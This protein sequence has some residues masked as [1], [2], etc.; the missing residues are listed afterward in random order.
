VINTYAR[1]AFLK[2]IHL[3]FGLDDTE[4]ATIADQLDETSYLAGK[5]IYEQGKKADSFYLIHSGSVKIVRREKGKDKQIATLVANDYFGELALI[6]RRRRSATASALTDTVLLILS[7]E[8]FQKL[9]KLTPQFKLNLDV[10]VRSRKLA[11]SLQFK[12]LAPEEVIYFLA[13]K[14][15]IVLAQN[16]ILPVLALFVP[17]ILLYFWAGAVPSLIVLFAGAASLLFILVWMAWLWIDWGNDYYIVTNRRVVWL[18]KVIAVFDSRQESPLNTILAV[19]VETGVLG[20]MLDY[21]DVIVRT[22]VGKVIFNNVSHPKQAQHMIE[23]YWHR[24]QEMAVGLEKE[25]MKDAIRRKLGL[26][27][28]PPPKPAAVKKADFP[29]ERGIGR[30]LRFFGANRLR[31][32]YKEGDSVIYRKHWFV[33]LQQAWIPLLGLLTVIGLFLYRVYYMFTHPEEYIPPEGGYIF[34]TWAA[35]FFFLIFPLLIWLIY[36]IADWSNDVFQVTDEQ[37]IDMD[38]KPL[39]T[40]TRNASQLESILGTEYK[41]VG[42]LGE[43]FN[44]GTVYITV[45]GTKLAFEDVIDPATV[46]SDIDRRRMAQAAR[47]KDKETAIERDRMAEW[48]VAYHQNAENFR[49][50][51]EQKP[52]PE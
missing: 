14:H 32:R 1:L 50:E 37:I 8:H 19:A 35:A 17:A 28:A 6:D 43:M 46:Q 2:K 26:Q 52:K 41:R 29:R 48:L 18:E 47:K 16:L 24:T 51:Q 30:V 40:Q 23:E 10:A 44:F 15:P 49:R 13:R 20:R 25:A 12:W 4:L 45:G 5:M 7:R 22:F 38:K 9:L 31:L 42:I 39:G 3:F 34:D 33:L 21:G 11:R 27:T 36:E